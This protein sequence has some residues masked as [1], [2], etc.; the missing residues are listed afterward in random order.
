MMM[1]STS[2]LLS[3]EKPHLYH[4]GS[5]NM[6]IRS[7][8]SPVLVIEPGIF[9]FW[10]ST[11]LSKRF[12]PLVQRDVVHLTIEMHIILE[13]QDDTRWDVMYLYT[14]LSSKSIPCFNSLGKLSSLYELGGEENP[15][16]LRNPEKPSWCYPENVSFPTVRNWTC[17]AIEMHNILG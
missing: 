11:W 8:C 10:S 14:Y 6:K 3:H 5:S 12:A 1:S 16:L 7:H 2:W 9:S 15:L 13:T 4:V 17:G